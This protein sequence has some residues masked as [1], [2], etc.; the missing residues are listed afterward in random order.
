VLFPLSLIM[1]W[2]LGRPDRPAAPE[3]PKGP[4]KPRFA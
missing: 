1:L 4:R 2:Y 3:A